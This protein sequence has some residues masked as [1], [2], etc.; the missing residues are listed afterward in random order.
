MFISG[1]RETRE[2]LVLYV[3]FSICILKIMSTHYFFLVENRDE[4]SLKYSLSLVCVTD[5]SFLV[6]QETLMHAGVPKHTRNV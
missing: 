6:I 4:D 5:F 1:K 2:K 3:I